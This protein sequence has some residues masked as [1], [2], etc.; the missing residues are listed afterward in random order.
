MRISLLI[1][2]SIL[3]AFGG[4][5]RTTQKG[6]V[7]EYNEKA[8][9]TPLAGVELRVRHAGSTVSDNRGE[10]LLDFPTLNPGDNISVREIGKD[11]YE[12]FNKDAIEQWNVNPEKPF[13]VVMCRSDKFKKIK[14]NYERVSS[15]SYDRQM[16]R[17]QEELARL[18]SEGRI[19][20]E[21]YER[22]L[23]ELSQNYEAQLDRLDAYVE[24]FARIDLSE[25]SDGEQEII[26]LVSEG[27][28][29]EAIAKYE[30]R[31]YVAQYLK[32]RS[33]ISTIANAIDKLDALRKDK[34]LSS[35]S[36]LAAVDRQID[37]Y[38]LAGGK[39]NFARAEKIILEIADADTTNLE[40]QLKA[41]RF[42]YWEMNK[43]TEAV[44]YLLR[45]TRSADYKT[46][47]SAKGQLS[48]C[49]SI[50]GD[51][52]SAIELARSALKEIDHSQASEELLQ[53]YIV[54]IN[55]ENQI[56][57]PDPDTTIRIL[58]EHVRLMEILS[59]LK[60]ATFKEYMLAA[61]AYLAHSMSPAYSAYLPMRIS[62]T[63]AARAQTVLAKDAAR[64]QSE[65]KQIEEL[66]HSIN[67]QVNDL[68]L[69][70]DGETS[71]EG[72]AESV[73]YFKKQ[74]LHNP[75]RFASDYRNAVNSQLKYLIANRQP[76]PVE[77]YTDFLNTSFG[78]LPESR[79]ELCES[80]AKVMMFG[81]ERNIYD[82]PL[83][84][85]RVLEQKIQQP[86]YD[87]VN[88]SAKALLCVMQA[89]FIGAS[90]DIQGYKSKVDESIRFF[91]EIEAKGDL[92][93][94]F[95]SNAFPQTLKLKAE[96]SKYDGN[97]AEAAKML[98]R[99]VGLRL[100]VSN[101]PDNL[102]TFLNMLVD[103]ANCHKTL[104]NQSDYIARMNQVISYVDY[105]EDYSLNRPLEQ[106]Y[107]ALARNAYDNG[108]Y[109]QALDLA[110]RGCVKS[111][112]KSIVL[113]NIS[114]L[115]WL[116]SGFRHLAESELN[117]IKKYAGEEVWRT[118]DLYKALN[119]Q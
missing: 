64:S 106:A 97:I 23:A 26:D 36:L 82:I 2:F 30:E 105:N 1:I 99:A 41:G 73:E 6:L 50:I 38:I 39:D 95:A 115:A 35:D 52:D 93:P 19:R 117:S 88:H 98:E 81:M 15:A 78:E 14:D 69:Q 58:Q 18:K 37:T 63:E 3:C 86:D 68:S 59:G 67:L 102:P 84:L 47:I 92:T 55:A 90:G 48:L 100:S 91:S 21:E 46:R 27:R 32:E 70:R 112:P 94:R 24:R 28:L 49:Y 22:K 43:N 118:C 83:A 51:I 66:L 54:Y 33:D 5:A 17:E 119:E 116:K 13:T 104:G 65:T 75:R 80:L 72:V 113:H 111:N 4:G 45:A 12:V 71:G 9:K 61:H 25:L 31:N 110:S 76:N 29:D 87:P 11:G 108:N 7:K 44:P 62:L 10:F 42:L 60:S 107:S 89:P 20:Q 16:R 96:L 79:I 56:R 103:L 8:R 109:K 40:R 85:S 57:N 114:G 74:F 77:L 101:P 53:A 34:E